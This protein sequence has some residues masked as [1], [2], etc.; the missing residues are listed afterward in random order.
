LSGFNELMG[1]LEI[2]NEDWEKEKRLDK[3]LKSGF[4]FQ[5]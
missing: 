1:F 5:K 4:I 3:S 2:T